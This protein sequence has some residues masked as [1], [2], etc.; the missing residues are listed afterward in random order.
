MV[1]SSRRPRVLIASD[2]ATFMLP[3]ADAYAQ[4]GF[5]VAIGS[6]NFFL[7]KGEYDVVQ[8]LWPEEYCGWVPPNENALAKIIEA[9][10]YWKRHSWPVTILNNF[11]PHGYEGN[12]EFRDLYDAFFKYSRNV[13]Q[14]SR[15][16]YNL[17]LSEYPSA[18]HAPNTFSKYCAYHELRQGIAVREKAR[19]QL[20]ITEEDFVILVFGALR[21]WDEV[22]LLMTAYS[23]AQIKKKRLLVLSKYNE[24]RPLTRLGRHLRLLRWKAWLRKADAIEVA[25]RVSNEELERYFL[26]ADV[27]PVLRINDM[28][29][30]AVGM[31]MTFGK[32]IVAP[33]RGSYPEMLAGTDNIIYKAGCSASLGDALEEATRVDLGRV[34]DANLLFASTWTWGSIVAACLKGSQYSSIPCV[35]HPSVMLEPSLE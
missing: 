20:G 31:A 35:Q 30:G 29:S 1:K 5:D 28:Y 3:L 25:G 10:A 26:A 27:V 8:Y 18:A 24:W 23:K 4:A 32:L 9:L 12:K 14:Y 6:S 13:V 21:F 7:Q 16:C 19:A 34:Q 11:R 2:E 15:I 22:R 33:D 17:C